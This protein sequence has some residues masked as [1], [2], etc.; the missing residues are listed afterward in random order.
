MSR[1]PEPLIAVKDRLNRAVVASSNGAANWR[2]V[3]VTAAAETERELERH[4]VG[5]E[6]PSKELLA[7]LRAVARCCRDA[8]GGSDADA[9]V[10][11]RAALADVGRLGGL[12]AGLDGEGDT[13][14]PG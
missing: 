10:L 2:D 4:T 13:R 11:L 5:R 1:P 3:V 7:C 6:V 12:S 14:S 9:A 8:V